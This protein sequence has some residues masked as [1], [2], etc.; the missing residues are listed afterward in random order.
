MKRTSEIESG[1]HL[2]ICAVCSFYLQAVDCGP[3]QSPVN[4]TKIGENSTF[5]TTVTFNCD[6]G[7]DLTGSSSRTCQANKQWTGHETFCSGNCIFKTI[8]KTGKSGFHHFTIPV[9][10]LIF[11][12]PS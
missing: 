2:D 5:L 10:I 4:G 11:S 6:D 9:F 3:L 7:F 1:K 12:L 8:C